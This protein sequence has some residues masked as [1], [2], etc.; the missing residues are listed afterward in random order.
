[1]ASL[2]CKEFRIRTNKKESELKKK[3]ERENKKLHYKTINRPL[4][5]LNLG[6]NMQNQISESNKKNFKDGA[7]WSL[8]KISK[9]YNKLK[10]KLFRSILEISLLMNQKTDDLENKIR[11]LFKYADNF[12]NKIEKYSEYLSPENQKKSKSKNYTS[13]TNSQSFADSSQR[14]ILSLSETKT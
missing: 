5:F 12:A 6:R 4:K 14:S 13:S 8:E 7:L 11:N 1:M 9:D 2:I 10:N 3:Y